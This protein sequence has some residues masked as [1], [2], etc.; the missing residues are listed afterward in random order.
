MFASWRDELEWIQK[1]IK[2][3]S[4]FAAILKI[5][6]NAKIY[7]VWQERNRRSHGY[8][9]KNVESLFVQLKNLVRDRHI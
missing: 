7:L 2:D 9:G 4:L 6:W 8:T 5:A 3:K 1:A